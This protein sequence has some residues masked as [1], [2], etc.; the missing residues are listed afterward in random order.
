VA[1]VVEDFYN[2]GVCSTP[3]E[4]ARISEVRM[5]TSSMRERG[6]RWVW[7][8][9]K[10][11]AVIAAVAGLVFWL[12]FAPLPA[13]RYRVEPGEIVGEVMGTGTLEARVKSTISPKIA[14][15]I[16]S[17]LVD[18]GDQVTAGQLLLTLDAIELQQQVEIAEA[19]VS[20]S[21]AAIERLKADEAQAAAVLDQ[22]QR[23]QA[24]ASTLW[25]SK[26][27]SEEDL[28][29]ANEGLRVAE[30]GRSRAEA[31]LIEGRQ[32]LTT[33]E[34]TL[35]Y[36]QAR[37][38]DTRIVAPFD[39]LIVRRLRDPGDILV[40]GSPALNLI[41]TGEIWISA[42]VDE[43]QMA[44]LEAGQPA[45][46]FFRSEP[47]R[48]YD[49]EVS[50][51]GRE[52]DRE[53]REFVVDVRVLSLPRNWAVG[54]RAEVYIETERKQ[55]VTVIPTRFVQWR[56]DQAGVLRLVNGRAQWQGITLGVQDRDSAEVTDGLQSGDVILLATG[57]RNIPLDGRR[58]AAP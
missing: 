7:R 51:L 58:I 56:E 4:N 10:G 32:Q 26:A 53:T 39:G 55:N 34:K 41:S 54:Q 38:A 16:E 17:I 27:I 3:E 21:Q 29:K 19:T 20:A 31:A 13:E 35:A 30:A 47:D 6:F 42:W 5:M 15:R 8:V 22:A 9:A 43:T 40:P 23:N 14:G 2:A 28:D 11:V 25:E 1:F 44:R 50:R 48:A 37:L 46:V 33:A 49:G 52:A 36:H 24:R 12:R 57:A 45:R 18:Q